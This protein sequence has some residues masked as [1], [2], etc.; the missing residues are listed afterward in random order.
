MLPDDDDEKK[1]RH[2]ATERT[3]NKGNGR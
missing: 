1:G 3:H 2:V